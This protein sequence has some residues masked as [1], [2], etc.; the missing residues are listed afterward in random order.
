MMETFRQKSESKARVM[1]ILLLYPA[2]K[3]YI[4]LVYTGCNAG[5]YKLTISFRFRY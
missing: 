4:V 3:R 1:H 2:V 5:V